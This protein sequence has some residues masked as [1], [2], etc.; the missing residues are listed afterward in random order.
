M[1]GKVVGNFYIDVFMTPSHMLLNDTKE[2][3]VLTDGKRDNYV[4]KKQETKKNVKKKNQPQ[5]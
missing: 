2:Q 1:F 5:R 4:D 3:I